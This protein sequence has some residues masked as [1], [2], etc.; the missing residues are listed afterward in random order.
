[1]SVSFKW[2]EIIRQGKGATC[3]DMIDTELV[4][5]FILYFPYAVYYNMAMNGK[6]QITL[7][8]AN[9]LLLS[10]SWLQL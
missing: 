10:P 1:M 6:H 4:S 7:P 5:S 2:G 3:E 9:T 8:I